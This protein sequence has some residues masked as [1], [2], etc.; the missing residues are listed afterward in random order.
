MCHIRNANVYNGFN[1][2]WWVNKHRLLMEKCLIRGPLSVMILQMS[3]TSLSVISSGQNLNA[4]W[5]I[6]SCPL[7]KTPYDVKDTHPAHTLIYW[8]QAYIRANEWHSVRKM[9]VEIHNWSERREMAVYLK[10]LILVYNLIQPL[11]GR[12]VGSHHEESVVTCIDVI[13]RAR[14]LQINVLVFS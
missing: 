4:R 5:S 2:K 6:K 10:L 1:A 8:R 11:M 7:A 13:D 14:I 3:R 12:M 9:E